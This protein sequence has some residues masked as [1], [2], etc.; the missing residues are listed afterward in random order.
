MNYAFSYI[1]DEFRQGY[2]IHND[3]LGAKAQLFLV[4]NRATSV[5]AMNINNAKKSYNTNYKLAK[6]EHCNLAKFQ[7]NPFIF[8]L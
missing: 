2:F 7:K 8:C 6:K 4:K 3:L 5:F 1:A